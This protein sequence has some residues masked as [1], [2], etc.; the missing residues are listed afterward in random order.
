MRLLF[1]TA[2]F[3]GVVCVAARGTTISTDLTDIGPNE[4][5]LTYQITGVTF[6]AGEELDIYFDPAL[7]QTLGSGTATSDFSLLLFQP[8]SPFGAQ[9]DYSLLAL[10][11]NPSLNGPYSVAAMMSGATQPAPQPF[12]INQYDSTGTFIERTVFSGMTT[13]DDAAVPEPDA[14]LPCLCILGAAAACRRRN[15]LR[16]TRL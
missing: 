4:W 15:R 7:Y 13:V 5:R 1:T 14:F 6:Q 11:D 10:V 9:G 12:F 2:I 8:N 3:V 16:R